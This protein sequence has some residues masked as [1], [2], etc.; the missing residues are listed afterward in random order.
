[1]ISELLHSFLGQLLFHVCMLLV[2]EP[3]LQS[4]TRIVNSPWKVHAYS[5]GTTRIQVPKTCR[6][7]ARV[8]PKFLISR[9]SGIL[10]VYV[11]RLLKF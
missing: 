10:Y 8:I 5:P 4:K 2:L 3:V 6:M 1:V 7:G 11:F 9:T